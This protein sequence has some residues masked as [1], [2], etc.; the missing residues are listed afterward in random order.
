[1]TV[2]QTIDL[3]QR[4]RFTNAY[5]DTMVDYLHLKH[6]GDR[7]AIEAKVEAI[8]R[9]R[10]K[11][12]EM[13][14][15]VSKGES[16][17]VLE[18]TNLIKFADKYRSKVITPSGSV[19]DNT[20]GPSIVIQFVRD[21]KAFRK[22]KK[23]AQLECN[24]RGDLL[25]E[26]INKYL[27]TSAKI[28][29]NAAPG[30]FGSIH[31]WL[32]DKGNYNAITSVSRSLISY[33]YT[34]A[35]E[36]LG[37]NFAFYSKREVTNHLLLMNKYAPSSSEVDDI[38]NKYGLMYPSKDDVYTFIHHNMRKYSACRDIEWL[39][40]LLSKL[41]SHVLAFT[42][43]YN[44]LVNIFKSNEHY[45]RGILT[46]IFDKT[47]LRPE[48]FEGSEAEFKKLDGDLAIFT[49][50]VMREEIKV[51]HFNMLP[52]EQPDVAKLFVAMA[53]QIQHYINAINEVMNVFV[54]TD[55]PFQSVTNKRTMVRESVPIS[56]TDSVI[57]TTKDWVEWYVGDV[58]SFDNPS[59]YNVSAFMVYQ[60]TMVNAHSLYKYSRVHGARPENRDIMA[61][62]NEFAF[63]VML[64]FGAKKTYAS[65]MAMQEGV[66]FKEP[67]PDLKGV[68]LRSSD[69]PEEA[70]NFIVNFISKTILE[71]VMNGRLDGEALIDIVC[72][73][74][75]HI[76]SSI[77]NR[78]ST[79]MKVASVKLEADYKT[80]R[81]P[82]KV[83][84]VAWNEIF[85]KL[86]GELRPPTKVPVLPLIKLNKKRMAAYL[87]WVMKNHN[88]IY[89]YMKR[90]VDKNN[91]L[92]GYIGIGTNKIPEV[93]MPIANMRKI[94]YH[95]CKPLYLTMDLL[96]IR[97]GHDDKKLL[98]TDIYG[99][100]INE[101]T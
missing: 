17:Y 57:F 68:A 27:Q 74:E 61:M 10:I 70:S 71:N 49:A 37:G 48:E 11:V 93:L 97:T 30:A 38:I 80:D 69:I 20:K 95:C 50:I 63:P 99:T 23:H 8:V 26:S 65:L 28:N 79:Y 85:G 42:Y 21:K 76:Q 98:F 22:S 24:A 5:R 84:A 58:F 56:D 92:P 46:R 75:M 36:L 77:M 90:Y 12:P 1:M 16:S 18:K 91:G 53:A 60:L 33:A 89:P 66:F 47:T 94:I 41:P 96:N 67:R 87:E 39:D 45:S 29:I 4:P 88:D 40:A 78:D 52:D 81:A 9:E 83:Y 51:K 64:V 32:Y 72:E 6:G 86:H 54:Y 43:Y 82:A 3:V 14:I 62:K 7:A 2:D 25:G 59:S 31:N 15:E 19:Y 73:Q 55:V 44:N 101:E 35:E 34:T 13:E 100:P